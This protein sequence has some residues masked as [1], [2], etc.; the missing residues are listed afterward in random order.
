MARL[1]P[2][3]RPGEPGSDKRKRQIKVEYV[4]FVTD[5]ISRAEAMGVTSDDDLLAIYLLLAESALR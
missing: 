1:A 5:I 2:P 3:G 4:R